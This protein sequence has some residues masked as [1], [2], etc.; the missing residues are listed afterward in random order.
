MVTLD[1]KHTHNAG[2]EIVGAIP[3]PSSSKRV[4]LRHLSWLH[5]IAGMVVLLYFLMAEIFLS[6]CK[7]LLMPAWV[8]FTL[9]HLHCFVS[10]QSVTSFNILIFFFLNLVFI[11]A[12][13][14]Y[15]LK[16]SSPFSQIG[17]NIALRRKKQFFHFVGTQQDLLLK[18]LG[19]HLRWLETLKPCSQV[20]LCVVLVPLPSCSGPLD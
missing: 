18:D 20:H 13:C 7:I 14:V 16:F 12:K 3:D 8:T 1:F 19:L 5:S 15:F 6:L 10:P 4:T 17:S 11:S 2:M 9:L